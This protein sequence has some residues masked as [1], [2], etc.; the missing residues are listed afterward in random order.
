MQDVVGIAWR[1][2]DK[3]MSLR[4]RGGN[5]SSS[6]PEEVVSVVKQ[7]EVEGEQP[8]ISRSKQQ[9]E[10]K[11][12]C[13]QVPEDEARKFDCA[14]ATFGLTPF[15]C[16]CVFVSCLECLGRTCEGFSVTKRTFGL[17][18]FDTTYVTVLAHVPGHVPLCTATMGLAAISVEIHRVFGS[19]V[20]FLEISKDFIPSSLRFSS[21]YPVSCLLSS[22]IF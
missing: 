4:P 16:F 13:S 17:D 19:S 15:V 2:L 22:E 20:R 9:N 18:L 21:L 11:K 14:A 3:A 12:D 5:S 1:L 7:E 8:G 6:S 10:E